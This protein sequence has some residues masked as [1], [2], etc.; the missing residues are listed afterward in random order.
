VSAHIIIS[1]KNL[2]GIPNARITV[3]PEIVS[4]YIEKSGELVTDATVA[5]IGV[6]K[7]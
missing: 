3:R 4:P 6:I 2:V 5:V 7:N 1:F